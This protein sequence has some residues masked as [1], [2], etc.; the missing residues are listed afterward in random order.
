MKNKNTKQTRKTKM[1]KNLRNVFLLAALSFTAVSCSNDDDNPEV[2]VD[3]EEISEVVIQVTNEN[4]GDATSYTYRPGLDTPTITVEKDVPYNFE[5]TNFNAIDGDETENILEE[6]A[7]E[8]EEHFIVYNVTV[9][10][11]SFERMDTEETT[12]EDGT[13]VGVSVDVT[14]SEA[15]TGIYNF[16]LLHQPTTVDDDANDGQG[17]AEGGATDADVT[18]ILEVE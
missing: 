13:K 1:M 4:S 15:G 10:F 2:I 9:P 17:S 3:H 8:K 16:V 5:I 11:S 6:I 18:Y 7:E 14:Y 12:R